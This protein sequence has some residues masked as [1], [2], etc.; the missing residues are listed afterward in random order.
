MA[1]VL[2]FVA[3][4]VLSF[5]ALTLAVSEPDWAQYCTSDPFLRNQITM[6]NDYFIILFPLFNN[7]M[8]Q[9]LAGEKYLPR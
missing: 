4:V 7:A 2:V 6:N 3:A 9:E 8:P 1:R 5:V